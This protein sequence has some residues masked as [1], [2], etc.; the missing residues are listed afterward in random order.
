[1]QLLKTELKSKI[2]RL[3]EEL[4]AERTLTK[5]LENQKERHRRQVLTSCLATPTPLRGGSTT[6]A[7]A[8]LINKGRTPTGALHVG[9]DC[10]YVD[11]PQAVPESVLRSL[12]NEA[13]PGTTRR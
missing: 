3:T 11:K 2:R 7:Q 9:M 10:V 8:R 6:H 5:A 1:V 4:Q 13:A 12:L